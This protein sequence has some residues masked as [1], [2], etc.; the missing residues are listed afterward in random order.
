MKRLMEGTNNKIKMV[1]RRSYGR[2]GV[3]LVNALMALPWY[4]ADLDRAQGLSAEAA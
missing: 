2:A 4:Y 1:R 3:E